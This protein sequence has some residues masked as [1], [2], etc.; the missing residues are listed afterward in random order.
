MELLKHAH[1]GLRWLVLVFLV[2]A[3]V[4]ALMKWQSKA[5]HKKSNNMM[6]MLAMA[7]TH[8]Q[9]V[10]GFILYFMSA[11]VSFHAGWMKDSAARFYGMEHI[12]MMVI[13]A[14]LITIGYSRAK[15]QSNSTKKFKTIFIFYAIG[16]LLILAAIPWPFRATLGG[17]W[18]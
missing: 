2:V 12:L 13:A 7:F 10:I 5:M 15:R 18:F 1:S 14:I 8:L 9:I 11:K 16:L 4:S 6:P 3:I 17:A